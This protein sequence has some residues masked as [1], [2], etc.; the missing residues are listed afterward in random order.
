MSRTADALMALAIPSVEQS[1]DEK[2]VILYALGVGVGGR[3]SDPS[4]LA[5]VYEQDLQVL[6]GLATV[7][8]HPGFWPRDLDTGLDWKK[9]VHGEQFLS[10]ERPLPTS[11]R[12]SSRS[13]IRGVVDKGEGKGLLINYERVLDVDG[14]SVA[15]VNQTL[16]CRGDG[17]GG[18]AGEPSPG[19]VVEPDRP[20]DAVFD[21]TPPPQ[22]A[23]IYR[24]S[25]DLNPLH[26]DPEVAVGAGFERPIL[27]GLATYGAASFS[28]LQATG[29]SAAALRK[30]D[31]RFRA[32]VFPGE[33]L[34]TSIWRNGA[35][36]QFSVAAV[37]RDVTV[38]S[39]GH[40][41]FAA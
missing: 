24:L 1:Y 34:T 13:R 21:L 29:L 6:P 41:E 11:G 14:D 33:R 28:L 15:V 17:G 2:D 7:L 12:A 16:F 9:I 40:A 39:H 26:A 8:A 23:L 32:A 36:V 25:G 10:I 20:P 37:D 4:E 30:L 38:I 3:P 5:F 27:H 22:A 35:E 18:S 19:L 31:C